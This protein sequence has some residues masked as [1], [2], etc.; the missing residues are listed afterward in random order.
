MLKLP[1]CI[2]LKNHLNNKRLPNLTLYKN[3]VLQ[4]EKNAFGVPSFHSDLD[5]ARY[6]DLDIMC[7]LKMPEAVT[8]ELLTENI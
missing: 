5:L 2:L 6:L 3:T 1:S 4:K 7:L 8:V